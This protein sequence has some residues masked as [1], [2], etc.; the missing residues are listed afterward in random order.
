M[1][2]WFHATM[3]RFKYEKKNLCVPLPLA[4]CLKRRWTK[5]TRPG[6]VGGG[7]RE[8][9]RGN[10]A[11]FLGEW[12]DRTGKGG[13]EVEW[14]LNVFYGATQNECGLWSGL[15]GMLGWI[16]W[17]NHLGC[18][19]MFGESPFNIYFDEP[20]FCLS[21]YLHA[22]FCVAWFHFRYLRAKSIL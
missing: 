8:I 21:F 15:L 19:N 18:H 5:A 4:S 14:P 17:Q 12:A 11:L 10:R 16:F 7:G 9:W 22:V 3:E 13:G 2:H 1:V 6:G 20:T